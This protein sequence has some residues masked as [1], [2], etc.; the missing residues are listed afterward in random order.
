MVQPIFSGSQ[1]RVLDFAVSWFSCCGSLVS[2][3]LIGHLLTIISPG[4]REDGVW[5]DLVE[6]ADFECIGVEQTHGPL[7]LQGYELERQIR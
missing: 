3:V 6:L 4:V 7:L 5:R 1:T 2:D